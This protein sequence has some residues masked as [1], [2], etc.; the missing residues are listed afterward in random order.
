MNYKFIE[1]TKD[2]K[3]ATISLNEPKSYNA[4]NVP[5]LSE[6]YSALEDCERDEKIRVIILTGKGKLFSSGGNVKEFLQSIENGTAPKKIADISEILHKC[7]LKIAEIPKIVIGKIKGGAYGAGL[8]LVLA[9]DLVYAEEQAILDEAFVNVGLSIDAGGSFIIPRSTSIKKTKEFIW[10]GPFNGIKAANLGI[11]N[12]ALPSDKLDEYV[13]K[14]AEKCA[15][16]PPLNVK[17]VKLLLNK[18]Y[19]KSFKEQLD[20]EREIQIQVAGSKDFAEGVK[21]FFEKRKPNY[22]GK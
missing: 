8:N 15:K 3:I 9:C 10:L 21:A 4:L 18:T 17:N 7:V 16:L 6:L 5:I 2:D 20:N 12:E 19:L 1:L 14:I 13:Y 11:V 22:I